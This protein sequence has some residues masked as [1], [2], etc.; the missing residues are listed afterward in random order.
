MEEVGELEGK[1]SL[2]EDILVFK[3]EI[4]SDHLQRTRRLFF[5]A[6]LST[7]LNTRNEA[8][9]LHHRGIHTQSSFN[10]FL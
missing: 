1:K 9:R 3:K 4:G 7:I 10:A 8:R 2:F 6:F 5:F